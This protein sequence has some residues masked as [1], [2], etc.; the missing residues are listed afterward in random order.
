MVDAGTVAWLK[1][2][3]LFA[4]STDTGIATAWGVDASETE[5][6]SCLALSSAAATEAARQQD[7]LEGPLAVERHNVKGLRSDLIGRPVTIT[8]AQLGYDAGLTVFVI[9]AEEAADVERTYLT[10]LRKLT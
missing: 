7:F 8:V 3:V 1:G 2:G 4:S 9:G 6:V 10:V 5:I